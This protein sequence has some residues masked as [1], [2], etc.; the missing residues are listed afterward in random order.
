VVE[1]APR[2]PSSSSATSTFAGAD[3]AAQAREAC[4]ATK[5]DG[6]WSK[7]RVL[8]TYLNQ[9]FF[10]N[11]AY[12][13]EAASQTY[14]SKRA[15]ELTLS[16]AAL[17]AGLTQA[18]S[19]HN[20]FTAPG[21]ARA[22]RAVVLQAM[23][24]TG[25]ITRKRFRKANRSDLGLRRQLYTRIR[26]PYFFGYVRDRLIEAYG[27]EQVR[28]GGL[29]V[30]TTIVP[31]YQRLAEKAIRD[32]MYLPTD[33]A[34]ALISISPR[35]GAIRAMAAVIPNRPKNEFNLLSQARRQPG[36]TFKT[37]VL[38]AAVEMGVNPDST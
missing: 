32:T 17:L 29:R 9:V 31:R 4:L 21:R 3:R 23:L 35:T 12:G 16:E 30:Y 38:A 14:F 11:Q 15:S 19:V 26:E 27:A 33:P 34:G 2:S 28:S 37:F 20:P 24:D 13:I 5:L 22:R 6:A 18:P 7:E 1:E 10:G 36:S 8:T 25:V